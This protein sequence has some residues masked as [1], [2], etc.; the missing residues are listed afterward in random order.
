MLAVVSAA[1]A[2]FGLVATMTPAAP[3]EPGLTHVPAANTKAPGYDPPDVL[4]PELIKFVEAQGSM[5]LENGTSAV[6]F[7]GYD[8]DGPLLPLPGA[9]TVEATKTEPDKNTYLVLQGQRG[10]DSAYN[11]GTHFVYQGHEGGSPGYI[12]RVNLDADVAHRVT[13]LATTDSNGTNL[14]TF[15]GSTWDP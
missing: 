9:P 7:Y 1:T 11:Y 10:A 4:S 5:R 3:V 2:A 8:G 6:P 14:P 12:T 13:L 15:D